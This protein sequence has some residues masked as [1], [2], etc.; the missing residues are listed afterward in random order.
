MSASFSRSIRTMQ[1]GTSG[2]SVLMLLVGAAFLAA[3][4][5][6]LML[7][8]VPVYAVTD[9]A[10]LTDPTHAIAQF[11]PDALQTVKPDQT[12]LLHLDAFSEPIPATVVDVDH[13]LVNGRFS[14]QFL[15][16]SLSDSN[17]PLQAGLNGRIEV[18][19]E[20]VTP[21]TLLLR[22]AGQ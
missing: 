20:Q 14:V 4:I 8:R 9:T 6:W 18:E 3:W 1:M 5:A 2:R 22:S 15:L 16:Q 10:V 17:I 21:F 11:S 13:T 7:A 12:G 19:V